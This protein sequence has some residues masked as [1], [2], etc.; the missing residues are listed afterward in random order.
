MLPDFGPFGVSAPRAVIVPNGG[1]QKHNSLFT[2][3]AIGPQVIFDLWS[4]IFIQRQKQ[5]LQANWT[6]PA[7]IPL[8]FNGGPL[9]P[10]FY[11]IFILLILFHNNLCDCLYF[12]E[13]NP[14]RTRTFVPVQA[15]TGQ[16]LRPKSRM[17]T[18]QWAEEA[19]LPTAGRPWWDR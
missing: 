1:G 17:W 19:V 16:R 12:G 15:L 14:R 4:I 13:M 10:F 18:F 8:L 2:A 9:L 7:I 6:S 5:Y 11:F 3:H